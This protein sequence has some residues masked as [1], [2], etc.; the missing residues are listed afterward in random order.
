MSSAEGLSHSVDTIPDVNTVDSEES[1]ISH[2]THDATTYQTDPEGST[3][4]VT[5]TSPKHKMRH[6]E[7]ATMDSGPGVASKYTES[8]LFAEM[9]QPTVRNKPHVPVKVWPGS[10]GSRTVEDMNAQGRQGNPETGQFQIDVPTD[11]K[12][13]GGAL[14]VLAGLAICIAA[15]SRRKKSRHVPKGIAFRI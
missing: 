15:L 4:D 11:Y 7:T 1:R 9:A 8:E 3:S 14:V 13:L 6:T 12:V 2:P 10:T 5:T